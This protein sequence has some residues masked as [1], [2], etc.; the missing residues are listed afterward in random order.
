MELLERF[1]ILSSSPQ[2]PNHLPGFTPW[3][4]WRFIAP[5][6]QVCSGQ[7]SL[8]FLCA[9]ASYQTTVRC[10]LTSLWTYAY[11]YD[12]LSVKL[13]NEAEVHVRGIALEQIREMEMSNGNAGQSSRLPS[14][15]N[16]LL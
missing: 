4:L 1:P 9:T 15:R 12:K 10:E 13:S 16:A 14:G 3:R 2:L 5:P 6:S 8:A 11:L 7:R